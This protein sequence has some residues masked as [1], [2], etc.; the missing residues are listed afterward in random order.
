MTYK[1]KRHFNLRTYEPE[2]KLTISGHET[3]SWLHLL[4]LKMIHLGGGI[5]L[6]FSSFF[7]G[8]KAYFAAR[9]KLRDI[10]MKNE[11]VIY[12]TKRSR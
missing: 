10:E 11:K 3:F 12:F 5:A 6:F 1:W 8:I 7:L 4:G 9:R 2:E